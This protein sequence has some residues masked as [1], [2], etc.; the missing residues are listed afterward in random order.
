MTTLKWEWERLSPDL[1]E[2]S[3]FLLW[4]SYEKEKIIKYSEYQ[5]DL[6]YILKHIR[7]TFSFLR[8]CSGHTITDANKLA[9]D[10]LET[11]AQGI[12]DN[13]L[14][15][16]LD[17]GSGKRTEGLVKEVVLRIADGEFKSSN[18]DI[19]VL[20]AENGGLVSFGGHEVD[21]DL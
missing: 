13:L 7:T 10:V 1:I 14:Q 16:S 18:L 15:L 12:F 19:D 21:R 6:T 4:R 9:V 5:D 2:P 20:N 17:Q 11:S 3:S 8:L